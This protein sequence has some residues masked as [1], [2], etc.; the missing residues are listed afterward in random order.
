MKSIAIISRLTLLENGRK[1]I[2]Q[3]LMILLLVVIAASTLLFLFTDG[4]RMQMLKDLCSTS[5][6][7]GGSLLAIVL[8][9]GGIQSDIE[10][11]TIT[12]FV[13]RPM[14]K[15]QYFL[16][17]FL[18]N[19]AT[20]G[21]GI[22]GMVAVFAVLLIVHG[23]MPDRYFALAVA[24]TLL[25]VAVIAAFSAMLGSFMSPVIAGMMSILFI[26]GGGMKVDGLAHMI[27]SS[28]SVVTRVAL[29]PIYHLLP[30]MAAFN[31]KTMLV[32]GIGAPPGY[33]FWVMVYGMLY[34]AICLTIGG[35]CI[36]TREV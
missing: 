19:L 35:W 20:V 13:A 23:V 4:V 2:F 30:N 34:I 18:G 15:Q 6:T 10:N 31:F 24:F 9:A 1:Q 33:C 16:G 25:Q 21:L 17:K 29:T 5:I 8:C 11:R 28:P 26:I 36:S 27:D 32:Q 22:A 7:V 14:T 3:A 12:P